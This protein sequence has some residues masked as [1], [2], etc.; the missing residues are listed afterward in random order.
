MGCVLLISAPP[1]GA[2]T[3]VRWSIGALGAIWGC[4]QLAHVANKVAVQTEL[5]CWSSKML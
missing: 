4:E 5:L 3:V 2:Q 1:F